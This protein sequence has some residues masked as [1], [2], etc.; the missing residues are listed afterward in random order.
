MASI[1]EPRSSCILLILTVMTDGQR[2]DTCI[3]DPPSADFSTLG[4]KLNGRL[5]RSVL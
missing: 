3:A 5:C 2:S 1:N 4:I